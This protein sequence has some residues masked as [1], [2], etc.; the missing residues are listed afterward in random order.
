MKK[1]SPL[2]SPTGQEAIIPVGVFACEA[3]GNINK[4]FKKID[5]DVLKVSGKGGNL[6]LDDL[7]KPK[8]DVPTLKEFF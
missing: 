1:L 3:C 8:L 6:E 4:E 2:I 7:E 5:K